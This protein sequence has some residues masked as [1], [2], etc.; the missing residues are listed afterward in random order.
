MKE[1]SSVRGD[2][3]KRVR[4]FSLG[5]SR[6][7]WV[8]DPT[9]VVLGSE[10]GTEKTKP[11]LL[12]ESDSPKSERSEPRGQNWMLNLVRHFKAKLKSNRLTLEIFISIPAVKNQLHDSFHYSIYIER[13]FVSGFGWRQSPNVASS[14]QLIL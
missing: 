13:S 9:V 10:T 14:T 4:G 2:R 12:N 5:G 11:L 7:C 8:C 6:W 1:I 3:V